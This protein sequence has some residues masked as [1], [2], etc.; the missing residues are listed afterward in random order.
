[1]SAGRRDV[2]PG[3]SAEADELEFETRGEMRRRK[4]AR[5]RGG[6]EVDEQPGSEV[7]AVARPLEPT[8]VVKSTGATFSLALDG[9][10][11][12]R[13]AHYE[14]ILAD[15]QV[16]REKAEEQWVL[17]AG[18][19]LREV[20]TGLFRERGFSDF[21]TYLQ[22]RWGFQK[23]YATRLIQAVPVIEA[24]QSIAH[25]EL[26]ERQMRALV[27]VCEQHGPQAVREVWHAAA[28]RGRVSGAGLEE[29]ARALGYQ[30]SEPSAPTPPAAPALRLQ[31]A[32]QR[33]DSSLRLAAAKDPGEARRMIGELRTLLDDIEQSFQA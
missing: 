8:A 26:K 17:T 32:W 25:R 27:G 20:R 10:D 23:A 14:R 28:E 29:A 18:Q 30:A 13:L 1:M 7:D 3:F 33:F 24:L 16:E 12:E 2:S 19:V 21:D 15:A 11:M 5:Q 4:L 6:D 9:T 31:A 22:E